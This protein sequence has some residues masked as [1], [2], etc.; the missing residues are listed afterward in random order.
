MSNEE[1]IGNSI[2]RKIW[3]CYSFFTYKIFSHVKNYRQF[4]KGCGV[5]MVRVRNVSISPR[6]LK[7]LAHVCWW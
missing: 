1:D 4:I 7:M 3:W 2:L 6:H 5:W